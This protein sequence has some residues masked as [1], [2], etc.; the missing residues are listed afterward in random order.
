MHSGCDPAN[1]ERLGLHVLTTAPSPPHRCDPANSER[2]GLLTNKMP[3]RILEIRTVQDEE[4]KELSVRAYV[5][6]IPGQS[7]IILVAALNEFNHSV[8]RF[9]SVA[10]YEGESP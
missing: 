5:S 7:A 3:V 6:T 1:S 9:P 10:Q 8:Q 4:T 2:L